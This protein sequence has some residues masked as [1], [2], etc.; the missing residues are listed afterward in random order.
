MKTTVDIADPLF[1]EAKAEAERSGSTLRELIE[2]GLRR[3]LAQRRTSKPFRLRD[4][5]AS[6]QPGPPGGELR[7]GRERWYA[8]MGTDGFPQTVDE[9]NAMMDEHDREQGKP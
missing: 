5:S 3:E 6:A 9:I 2:S 1:E 4:A 7:E 8:Y